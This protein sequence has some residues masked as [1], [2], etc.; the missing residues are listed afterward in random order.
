M[1]IDNWGV[2]RVNK[3]LYTNKKHA[4]D[5]WAAI[6]ILFIFMVICVVAVSFG[7]NRGQ[8]SVREE[9]V[10]KGYAEFKV[11]GYH[12]KSRRLISQGGKG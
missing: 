3:H 5:F 2:L 8:A 9:A 11:D 4:A 6:F 7:Y 1:F 12:W 10:D